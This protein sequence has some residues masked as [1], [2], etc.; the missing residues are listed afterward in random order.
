MNYYE[1]L[2][3]AKA[4]DDHRVFVTFEGGQTGVFVCNVHLCISLAYLTM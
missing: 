2:T 1:M 3:D 4:I